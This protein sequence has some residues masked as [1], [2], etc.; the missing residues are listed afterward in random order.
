[1][2]YLTFIK[3]FQIL[4]CNKS[5]PQN[6]ET[7][8]HWCAKLNSKDCAKI[9]IDHGCDATIVDISGSTPLHCAAAA[10]H[11]EVIP[12][13]L[14]VPQAVQLVQ[15]LDNSGMTALDLSSNGKSP[16][17][18][19]ISVL[20]LRFY[21]QHHITPPS[22]AKDKV[23]NSFH[24]E[25]HSDDP[26]HS[27]HSEVKLHQQQQRQQQREY[28]QQPLHNG[29]HNSADHIIHGQQ[30]EIAAASSPKYSHHDRAQSPPLFFAARHIAAVPVT[31]T[32]G[33]LGEDVTGV[34]SMDVVITP[35][36]SPRSPTGAHSIQHQH[37][38]PRSLHPFLNL[39]VVT[40][41]AH[42]AAHASAPDGATGAQQGEAKSP[43][44][45]PKSPRPPFRPSSLNPDVS[46]QST[47]KS[48]R[49]PQ[50]SPRAWGAPNNLY[51]NVETGNND[52]TVREVSPTVRSRKSGKS[53][54][55]SAA[56]SSPLSPSHRNPQSPKQQ[57]PKQQ[58]PKQQSP[59]QQ[60]RDAATTQSDGTGMVKPSSSKEADFNALVKRV[61][62]RSGVIDSSSSVIG[63]ASGVPKRRKSLAHIDSQR[64]F[65]LEH[66]LRQDGDDDDEGGDGQGNGNRNIRGSS[67]K[68]LGSGSGS[69]KWHKDDT[70]PVHRTDAKQ[71]T[72]G[73]RQ[74]VRELFRDSSNKFET[75]IGHAKYNKSFLGNGN[76]NYYSSKYYIHRSFAQSMFPL[77]EKLP[78]L[79]A[80]QPDPDNGVTKVHS[81]YLDV[82]IAVEHC[83]DCEQ[84][85][86][87]SLRHDPA[88]YVKIAND[89]LFT[90]IKA[91]VDSKLA[92]RLYALRVKP[93]GGGKDRLGAME[94]TVAANITCPLLKRLAS[95]EMSMNAGKAGVKAGSG[96]AIAGGGNKL[97]ISA[98][99]QRSSTQTAA[100]ALRGEQTGHRQRNQSH[101]KQQHAGG[102]GFE[103]GVGVGGFG[104]G[105]GGGGGGAF[106]QGVRPGSGRQGSSRRTIAQSFDSYSSA[107]KSKK[108]SDIAAAMSAAA[109]A[110]AGGM[111]HE[112][113]EDDAEDGKED[114]GGGRGTKHK[115][116]S[117][118]PVPKPTPPPGW[119]TLQAYSK[120]SSKT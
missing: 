40:N 8:L 54:V 120:L 111:L 80:I 44:A 21:Q 96:A 55:A 92:V 5:P 87:Q 88:K 83:T 7:P 107:N 24:L 20:L 2:Q 50:Q 51:H 103:G 109:A 110:A 71:L 33:G 82:I 114:D 43:S 48:P 81:Q 98:A 31:S 105:E 69:G 86:K 16:S 26:Y 108:D 58:S 14:D 102:G 45:S 97:S 79:P 76:Q 66:F 4:N 37:S 56:S 39:S 32:H 49:S 119:A 13:M 99:L 36:H 70:S 60:S 118:L 67:D 74:S 117:A 30:Q 53:P 27:Q 59:K 93:L 68:K 116:A 1:M 23:R 19:A 113:D 57:S 35:P 89:V 63:A 115:K 6:D 17:Y 41:G 3:F 94:I 38:H 46:S 11:V 47:P 12:L 78:L 22:G 112:E 95:H 101:H 29:L 106:G 100:A 61:S 25:A 65:G 15:M 64:G 9:L 77:A 90:L 72:F 91:V 52:S 10:G 42:G 84:H 73:N 34:S 62:I 85:N 104:R 18:F 75:F 28:E